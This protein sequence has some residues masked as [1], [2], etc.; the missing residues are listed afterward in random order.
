MKKV[1]EFAQKSKND[2]LKILS[3][4][5][6]NS[7]N[8]ANDITTKAILELSKKPYF[9]ELSFTICGEGR[10]WQRTTKTS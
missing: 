2:R 3:I 8:Y 10:L 4:R 6:F 7:K 1:F 9:N 5:S